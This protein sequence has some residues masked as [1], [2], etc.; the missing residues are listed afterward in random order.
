[1]V[2]VDV[3]LLPQGTKEGDV[4]KFENGMYTVDADAT[5]QRTRRIRQLMGELWED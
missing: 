1:M 3:K 5:L 4:L 2:D